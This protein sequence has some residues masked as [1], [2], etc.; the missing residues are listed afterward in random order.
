MKISNPCTSQKTR[1]A[2]T[3]ELRFRTAN[4]WKNSTRVKNSGA[5]GFK[6]KEKLIM[7]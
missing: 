1:K 4:F 2:D 5:V 7:Y 3:M 6:C